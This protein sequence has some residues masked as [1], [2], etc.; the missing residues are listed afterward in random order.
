M[1][2]TI[3]R[4]ERAKQPG[5]YGD[6]D[7]L[8]LQ[9]T[10][11]GVKSW[12]L[13]YERDGKERFM[14]LGPLHT[15]TL[16]AA[17]ERARQAR[18]KL[19]DGIDP[20]SHR[21]TEKTRRKV[22][23]AKALT[24]AQAAKAYFDEHG[25]EWRNA[26]HAAQ[27]LSTL[28]TYVF[29]IIGDLPVAEITT[30]L[31]LK[32]LE[33][34][35]DAQLGYPAG[36]FW[37]VRRETASRVRQRIERVL[38][39]ATVREHRT[40]DNPSR[41]KGHLEEVLPKRAAAKIEHHPA[42]PYDELPAFMNTLR[43]R[44]GVAAQALQF[45]IMTAART[46]GVIGASW[47]EIDLDNAVWTIPAQRMKAQAEH[48]VPLSDRAVEL[49]RGLYRERDNSYVFIGTQ[50]G[51]GLSNM[52]MAALLDRMGRDDITVHGFRSTFRDWAA[53]RSS[54]ANEVVEMSL[55]HT[56]ENKTERAYRR[57]DLLDKRRKLMDAWSAYC[58][59]PPTKQKQNVVPMRKR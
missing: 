5:R 4:V 40:G 8:Y 51:A 33:Q 52:A 19:L 45:L 38:D 14:G 9:V 58:W 23:E 34:K 44:E 10:R 59:S 57:G 39:W 42:L 17:R 1:G 31:V 37:D 7:G 28:K 18:L 36:R 3:K 46:G 22:E 55:A 54:F 50:Q 16:D 11:T 48:R 20:I 41:W 35:I 15:V 43:D 56:I 32:V 30:P 26:K 47:N 49:L 24:F 27:F 2:L 53:E 12:I 21:N 13:R 6:G 25:A 29:P